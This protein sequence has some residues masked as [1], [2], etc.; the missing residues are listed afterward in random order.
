MIPL[1]S[2]EVSEVQSRLSVLENNMRCGIVADDEE[3]AD[4]LSDYYDLLDILNNKNLLGDL[5]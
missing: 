4:M 2:Y 3:I 5:I 1:T